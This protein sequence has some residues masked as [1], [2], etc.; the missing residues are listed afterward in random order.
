MAAA[1]KQNAKAFLQTNTMDQTVLLELQL[2]L[3]PGVVQSR[4][5][6]LFKQLL[7]FVP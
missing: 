6:Q 2:L 7:L 3:F 4:P 1:S 5:F